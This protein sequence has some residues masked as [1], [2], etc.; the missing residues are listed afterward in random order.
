MALITRFTIL[1]NQI[2]RNHP[3]KL[4]SIFLKKKLL[5]CLQNLV[6]LCCLLVRFSQVAICTYIATDKYI[7]FYG[8]VHERTALQKPQQINI[9]QILING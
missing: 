4:F 7:G 8:D 9:L 1:K 2:Y 5:Q 6:Y 3:N